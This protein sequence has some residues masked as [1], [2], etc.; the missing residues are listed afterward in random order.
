MVL[1]RPDSA[2]QVLCALPKQLIFSKV[3]HG[4][5]QQQLILVLVAPWMALTVTPQQ[6]QL[7]AINNA[8]GVALSVTQQQQLTAVNDAQW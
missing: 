8:H 5:V 2:I 6:Q 4:H 1:C 7:F 3:V